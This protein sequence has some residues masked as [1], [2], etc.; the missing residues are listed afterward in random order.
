MCTAPTRHWVLCK[1]NS[2]DYMILVLLKTRKSIVYA[3]A[4]ISYK[5]PFA[6]CLNELRG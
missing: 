6:G 5:D 4:F 3:G 2:K 1:N